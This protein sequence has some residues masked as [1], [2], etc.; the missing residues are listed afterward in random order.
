MFDIAIVGAGPAGLSAA[1]NAVIRNKKTIVF[2]NKPE[3]SYL[4][5]AEKV[6]NYLG[7]PSLSGKE[8]IE[9]FYKHAID[10][11]VKIEN[12]KVQEIFTMGDYYTLNVDNEF[13]EASKVII[14]IGVPKSKYI[15]GEKEYMGKGVSYCATCDGLLY[16]NKTVMVIGETIEAEEDV[17]YLSEICQKVYYVPTY[18]NI[19]FK[20]LN[21]NIEVLEGSPKEIYGNNI[22]EGIKIRDKNINVQGIFFIRESIPI[23]KLISGLEMENNY[24]KVNRH[25]ETNFQGLYAAGDCTGKPLQLGKAVGEGLIAAQRA[26][27]QLYKINDYYV[28]GE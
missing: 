14:T 22:I 18:K 9:A 15:K 11:G 17:Q 25:M 2:G 28:S 4:Y 20:S 3:S 27:Q 16:K 8:I 6:D 19:N 10:A 13:Y 1:I 12:K 26:V 7:M 23:N 24:I 21:T 5:K